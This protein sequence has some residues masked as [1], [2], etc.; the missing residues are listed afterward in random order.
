MSVTQK[1]IAERMGVSRQLVGLA[2]NGN[3]S[4]SE[5]TR[6]RIR[7][8]A[9][10]LGY[11]L[12][13]NRDARALI[14]KRYNGRAATGIIAVM[15]P[16]FKETPLRN[17]PFFAPYLD[18]IEIQASELGLDILICS[19]RSG[20]IPR[21][22]SQQAVDGIVCLAA[23]PKL[24]RAV[25]AVGLPTISLGRQMS[26]CPSVVVE[27]SGGTALATEHLFSLGHRALAY[28]GHATDVAVGRE[29]LK[30]FCD[31]HAKNGLQPL[32]T[33][34]EATVTLQI[35]SAGAEAMERILSRNESFQRM[36]RP[37]F[38]GLICY[39]D[40]LAM[41]AIRAALNRGLRV[42]EDLSVTG[43][44]DIS[45]QYEFQPAITSVAFPRAEMGRRALNLL[46]EL[47]NKE[48]PRSK[49]ANRFSVSLSIRE[50]TAKPDSHR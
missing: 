25:K 18:G 36:G 32:D 12:Y 9:E 1:I 38:T 7:K 33:N 47:N 29:R 31:T 49:S 4:V 3:P 41:G 16:S 10:E 8:L 15:I 37:D 2:L 27:D 26:F 6:E 46:Q 24:V 14:A 50:S 17:M 30:G 20:Q 23:E 42:P 44:D 5:E 34:I 48:Q 39:N 22:I 21:P 40:T 19:P 45:T 43:F 11:D 35:S 13:S 28:I